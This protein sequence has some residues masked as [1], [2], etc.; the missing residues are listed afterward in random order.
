MALLQVINTFLESTCYA[1]CLDT[2]LKHVVSICSK[3]VATGHKDV[4]RDVPY[5]AEY[6]TLEVI[7]PIQNQAPDLFPH[8]SMFICVF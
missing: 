1:I 3:L 5:I 2:L 4:V 7:A 8:L 6:S